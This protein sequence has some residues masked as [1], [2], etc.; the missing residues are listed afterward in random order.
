LLS[1]ENRRK[2]KRQ[3]KISKNPETIFLLLATGNYNVFVLILFKVP[4]LSLDKI[5]PC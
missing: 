2:E 4:L 3:E 5:L 1:S